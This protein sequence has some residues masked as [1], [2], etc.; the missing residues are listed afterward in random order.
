MS[1][2]RGEVGRSGGGVSRPTPG[3]R[4]GGSGW[5]VS[6]P[7]PGGCPG[8]GRGGGGG[9]QAQARGCLSVCVSALRQTPPLADGYCCVQYASYWN[10]FLFWMFVV[11]SSSSAG[12]INNNTGVNTGSAGDGDTQQYWERLKILRARCGLENTGEKTDGTSEPNR[13]VA[14]LQQQGVRLTDSSSSL[15]SNSSG[16]LVRF[17][18]RLP[19]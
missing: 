14:A 1:R 3:A 15:S 11:T 16:G 18:S 9:V 5:G 2:P 8:P 7:K 19:L 13:T 10:R 4:F 17:H 12:S 6:R